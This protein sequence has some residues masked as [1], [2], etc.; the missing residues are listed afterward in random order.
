MQFQ[1]T[2]DRKDSN[3]TSN[4][5]HLLSE[6][7]EEEIRSITPE[8][9]NQVFGPGDDTYWDPER[10]YDSPEWY[11][12]GPG[13]VILGIGFRWGVPRL[14]GKNLINQCLTPEDI[15][16]MFLSQVIYSIELD[17]EDLEANTGGE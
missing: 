9:M 3:M 12:K 6:A 13:G 14:R 1:L 15:C 4:K 2:F 7:Y 5:S 17:Q 8:I 10:G 16:S 11:F